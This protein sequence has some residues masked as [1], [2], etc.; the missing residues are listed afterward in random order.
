MAANTGTK[1]IDAD[2]ISQGE[3]FRVRRTEGLEGHQPL[4]DSQEL[5]EIR[6]QTAGVRKK[7]KGHLSEE[8]N[9][10][11]RGIQRNED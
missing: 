10:V 3:F 1:A 4:R 7:A 2:E 6:E 9:V 8:V 5:T 11:Q